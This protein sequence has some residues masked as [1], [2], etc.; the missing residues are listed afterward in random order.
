MWQSL[1]TQKHRCLNDRH[2]RQFA[3]LLALGGLQLCQF[4]NGQL[5][6]FV[7]GLQPIVDFMT[8]LTTAIQPD[9]V[10]SVT[11]LFFCWVIDVHRSLT[12]PHA[13]RPE[14]FDSQFQPTTSC[15]R[16][17]SV[18][19]EQNRDAQNQTTGLC[20]DTCRQPPCQGNPICR[21]GLPKRCI[22]RE[23]ERGVKKHVTTAAESV[24]A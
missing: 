1:G 19:H 11:N 15:F 22:V 18:R 16:V 4:A 14:D 8:G 17:R 20:G 3:V 24:P 9:L 13:T 2:Q 23:L 5:D 21:R 7:F 12:F 6:Q 10:G